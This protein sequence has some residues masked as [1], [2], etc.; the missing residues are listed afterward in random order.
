MW[1]SLNHQPNQDEAETTS[2]PKPTQN[3]DN[4]Q[5]LHNKLVHNALALR[6]SS[7]L[8]LR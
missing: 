2:T 6:C 3:P 8:V 5:Q 4:T 7:G 1:L